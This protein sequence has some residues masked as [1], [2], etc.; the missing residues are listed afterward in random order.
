MTLQALSRT[1]VS[2]SRFLEVFDEAQIAIRES[3]I[4]TLVIGGVASAAYG[5]PRWSNDLD[6]FVR[7][8]DAGGLLCEFASRGFETDRTYPDWLFKAFKDGVLVDVIF[9]SSGEIYM[10]EEMLG[11]AQ[12]VAFHGREF[13]AAAPEDIVVMK[14]IAHSEPT[15]RYWYDALGIV[16]RTSLDWEYLLLR[17]RQGPARVLSFLMYAR[18]LDFAVPDDVLDRLFRTVR[19]EDAARSPGERRTVPF[20]RQGSVGEG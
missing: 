18:S 12:V 14:A 4:P 11:R 7:Q 17:G 9:K 1:D 13:L 3:G 16:S 6:L 2:E 19:G 15:S 10:D 5:R 8:E 20:A